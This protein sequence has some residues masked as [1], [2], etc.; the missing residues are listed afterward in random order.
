MAAQVVFCQADHLATAQDI[1]IDLGNGQ[2][3]ALG[4]TQQRVGA[5]VD[6]GL[7]AADFARGGKTVE[8]HLPQAHARLT[9]VERFP[10]VAGARAVGAFTAVAGQHV[11][12]WQVTAFGGAQLVIGS[13]SAVNPG[14]DFRVYLEGFLHGLWQALCLNETG[15]EDERKSSEQ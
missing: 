5:G 3:G 11:D 4:C 15:G 6:G 2:R 14:L 8:D 13:D 7:L 12:A 10:A 1:Q 9:A